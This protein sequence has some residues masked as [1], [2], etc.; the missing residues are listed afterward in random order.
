MTNFVTDRKRI[1]AYRVRS[2]REVLFQRIETSNYREVDIKIFTPINDYYKCFPI[3]H[4]FWCIKE[5]SQRDVYFTYQKRMFLW[6]NIQLVHK[7]NK[8][9]LKRPLKKDKNWVSRPVIA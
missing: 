1:K 8:T 9:C 5:T 6:T 3:R 2:P 7:Y 4:T